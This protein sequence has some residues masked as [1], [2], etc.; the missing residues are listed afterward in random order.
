MQR[1]F[2]S[3][4]AENVEHAAAFYETLL[5]MT[6]HFNS[7]WFIILTHPDRPDLEYGVLDRSHN[8]VPDGASGIPSGIL[9]TFVV[10]DCD[11]VH[12]AALQ[13][14]YEIVEPPTDMPYGQRRMILKDP[15][16]TF[17]DISSP[18]SERPPLP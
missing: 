1:C 8:V 18:A 9:V 4:L 15:A 3:I 6:R 5:G 11:T 10:A 12:A 14:G 16:G 17:V 7:D 13:R 2:T